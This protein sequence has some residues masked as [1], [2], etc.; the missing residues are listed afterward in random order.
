MAIAHDAAEPLYLQI[1][2]HILLAIRE[3]QYRP[4]ERLPSEREL[5][6]A[7]GISRMTARQ[8]L[9]ELQRSGSVY[10]RV[11]KGTFVSP[12]KIEQQLQMVTSFTQEMRAQGELPSSRVLKASIGP[13]DPSITGALGIEA[14]DEVVTLSRLRLANGRPLGLE[15][16]Y[17]PATNVPGLLRHD[18]ERESLYETLTHDY[19]LTLF[20]ASQTIE[21]ALAD[22]RELELLE[23]SSPAAVLRLQR[24]TRSSDGRSVEFVISTYR[25]DMYRLHSDLEPSGA[26]R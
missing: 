5:S 3:G 4:H 1:K 23:M 2:E 9:V 14:G 12:P 21:A 25:G 10:A 24:L 18:F 22:E 6:A 11:G 15:T 20:T 17:L 26:A 13:V 7:H 16:A 8:A 19:S